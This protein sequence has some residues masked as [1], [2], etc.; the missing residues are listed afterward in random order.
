[1]IHYLWTGVSGVSIKT[2]TIFL[3][4]TYFLFFIFQVSLKRNKT[5]L[6]LYLL[7]S[8]GQF[9]NGW[10]THGGD[11]ILTLVCPMSCRWRSLHDETASCQSAA[12]CHSLSMSKSVKEK[13][14][15]HCP[16]CV[17]MNITIKQVILCCQQTFLTF[18]R[19]LGK[20]S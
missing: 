14:I 2:V 15:Q 9:I 12:Q 8:C 1:M 7:G 11:R 18:K 3:F 4:R 17:Y 6:C 19:K 20:M 10:A 16:F 5:T 13:Q